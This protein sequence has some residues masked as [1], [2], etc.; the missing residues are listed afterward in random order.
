MFVIGHMSSPLSLSLSLSLTPSL[1][2]PFIRGE[3]LEAEKEKLE[4]ERVGGK[5]QYISIL[6]PIV[7]RLTCFFGVES[8]MGRFWGATLDMWFFQL[9]YP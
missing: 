7:A 9:S 8:G 6:L 3:E 1:R 4:R 5:E 2:S